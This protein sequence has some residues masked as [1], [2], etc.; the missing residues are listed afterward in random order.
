MVKRSHTLR[1]KLLHHSSPRKAFC[2]TQLSSTLMP[3]LLVHLASVALHCN[4]SCTSVSSAAFW[5]NLKPYA[6]HL[7]SHVCEAKRGSLTAPGEMHSSIA[8][9]FYASILCSMRL[10]SGG[11]EASSCVSADSTRITASSLL[12]RK[13]SG[14]LPYPFDDLPLHIERSLPPF[15]KL[16]AQTLLPS[17]E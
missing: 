8:S 13:I 9:S 7:L 6:L 11:G 2:S 15:G 1:T 14:L 5:K 17:S 16:E 3:T 4:T 10:V 12:R